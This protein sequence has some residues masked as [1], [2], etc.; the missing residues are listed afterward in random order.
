MAA[1]KDVTIGKI[2][3]T[4]SNRGLVKILPLTDF[5]DRFLTMETMV[6]EREGKFKELL[7]EKAKWHQKYILVKFVG[8]GDMTE[9]EGLKGYIVKIGRDELTELPDNSYYIFDIIGLR[10]YDENGAILG[11]VEDILQTGSNDVYVVGS[12]ENPPLLIP[13]LKQVIKD[14]DLANGKMTVALMKEFMEY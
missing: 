8:I 7:V 5:P 6:L 3:G 4:H 14:I 1:Q 12:A 2:I 13:A 9:A 11:Q 10:V